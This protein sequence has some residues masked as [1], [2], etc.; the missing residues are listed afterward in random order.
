MLDGVSI[1]NVVILKTKM[2]DGNVLRKKQKVVHV[3]IRIIVKLINV[4]IIFVKKKK[5]K[6]IYL[7][8]VQKIMIV[9]LEYVEIICVVIQ[10]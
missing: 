3:M 5:Q 6:K 2:M 9:L 1:V 8:I 10:V 7:I 4:L